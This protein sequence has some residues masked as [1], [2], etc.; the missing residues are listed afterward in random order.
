MKMNRIL[1]DDTYRLLKEDPTSKLGIKAIRALKELE[2]KGYISNKE[3]KYHSPQCSTPPQIY[4]LPKTN[5]DGMPLG[6]IVSAIGSPTYQLA[7]DPSKNP[8][9]PRW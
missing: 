1:E 9:P 7:Q 5:K 6:P 8:H 3:R 2:R 4:G